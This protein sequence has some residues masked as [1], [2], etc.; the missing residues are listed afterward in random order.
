[1]EIIGIIKEVDNLGRV[2]IPKEIR[3]LLNLDKEVEMLVTVDGL[4]IRNPKYELV[5]KTCK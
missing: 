5:E 1:M 4:L 3:A 2:V